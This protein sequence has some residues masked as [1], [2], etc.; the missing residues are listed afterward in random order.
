MTM[1]ARWSLRALALAALT[2]A[3]CS[4]TVTVID[5]VVAADQPAMF[6]ECQADAFAF[7]GQISLAGLGLGHVTDPAEASRVGMAWVTAG[8]GRG[9]DGPSSGRLL[10]MDYPDG[11]GIQME[12]PDDWVPPG[13]EV[14]ETT[15]VDWPRIGVVIGGV[16]LVGV[17]AL[18]F[19]RG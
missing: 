18:A 10:C 2:L 1:S 9:P 4:T 5:G 3:G 12:V 15:T 14:I 8:P 11:S 17:T 7:A 16:V 6:P 13:A 19:R